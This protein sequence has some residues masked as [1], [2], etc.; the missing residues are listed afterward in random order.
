MSVPGYLFFVH[1][2]FA[3]PAPFRQ[4]QGNGIRIPAVDG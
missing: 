3:A 2:T 4:E 1:V